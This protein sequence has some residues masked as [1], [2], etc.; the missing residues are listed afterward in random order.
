MNKPIL[1]LHLLIFLGGVLPILWGGV[2]LPWIYWVANKKADKELS[3]Q[4]CNALNFQ[5]MTQCIFFISMLSFWIISIRQLSHE[6]TPD[7][8]WMGLPVM[9]Y[10]VL[11]VIYPLGCVLYMITR[12]R[13]KLF[14]PK[15]IKIFKVT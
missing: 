3:E 13:T 6:L 15:S 9:L 1:N 12:K 10:L 7:Y 2:L 4:A 5:F 8:K 14:Y 11:C